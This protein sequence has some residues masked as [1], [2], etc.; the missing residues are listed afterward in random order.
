MLNI[1]DKFNHKE[2]PLKS[3]EL[4]MNK[5]KFDTKE[6]FQYQNNK[7]EDQIVL[8]KEPY[9]KAENCDLKL[10]F[11]ELQHIFIKPLKLV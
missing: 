8:H 3:F 11:Q 9:V 7:Y 5:L 2:F 10:S 6:A 4:H 1:F